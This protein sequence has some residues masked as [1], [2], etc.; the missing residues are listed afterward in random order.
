MVSTILVWF[1]SEPPPI[2]FLAPCPFPLTP[3]ILGIVL[4]AVYI[5]VA[6][7]LNLRL[8]YTCTAVVRG[9]HC[10]YVLPSSSLFS[11]LPPSSFLSPSSSLFSPPSSSSFLSLSSS[12]FLSSS[13]FLSLSL[14]LLPL[15]FF[16]SLSLPFSSLLQVYL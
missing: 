10:S 2:L 4:L 7:N 14:L 13:S 1:F 16:L 8:N 12:L 11:P 15:L 9:E 3:P 6:Q 5:H